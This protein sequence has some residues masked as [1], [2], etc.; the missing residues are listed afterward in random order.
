[1]FIEL[2]KNPVLISVVI[3]LILSALRLNVVFA[4]VI[5]ASAGGFIAGMDGNAI[6]NAF[7]SGLTNGAKVAF[8]YAMLG[9]FSIAIS[10]SGITE[11]LAGMLFKK[12]NKET[13]P[14]N[15]LFFKY[16]LLGILTLAAISSQNVIPVHIAFIPV[17]IPPLLS[18]FDRLQLDR[19]AVA[20]ILTF[21]L[22]T[23]YMFM[24]FGFGQ[25]YLNEILIKGIC[26][27]GLQVTA[28]MAPKAMLIPALGMVAGLLI[29][30]FVS[31]RKPRNYDNVKSEISET[32]APAAEVQ[33]KPL[34]VIAGVAA[35]AVALAG[36]I[37]LDSLV[38]AAL[39]GVL[40]FVISGV[41]SMRDT[42]DVFT[43]GVYLMGGIGIVLLAANG[44]AGVLKAT[45]TIDT[46]VKLLA[47]GI[48]A[49]KGFAVFFMLFIGLVI[50][51]G[52]GSS[53]STV[54]LIAAIYVPL[55]IKLG[56]SPLA[57]VAIVGVAG[58]LG[59]A[60]SPVSESVLGPTAGLN[61]DGKHDHIYD[62][63]IPTFIH[64]NLPLLA[65][66]WIA[67]MTL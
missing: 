9:A 31:Y 42:Q 52:I 6:M 50:T 51:M 8:S 7:N 19:R 25:I 4:L 17:L 23:P 2:I 55:C 65:A 48:G 37:W 32:H 67:G 43:K 14:R 61:A 45:G 12:L 59:D 28:D 34:N 64:Y 39:A 44:F 20:C 47:S 60:G 27:S 24:P 54:P 10:R 58:A 11:L 57:T 56:I 18:L 46:L 38:I 41:V 3:M 5:S 40:V 49:Q 66:G 35:I 62:S 13:T 22:I 21:G 33:V 29:A 36:Q 53:F 15:I 1:M 26:S 63:T 16:M 30:V